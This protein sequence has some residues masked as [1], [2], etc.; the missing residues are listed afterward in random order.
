MQAS[1]F[2]EFSLESTPKIFEALVATAR[3]EVGPVTLKWQARS[4]TKVLRYCW[5]W[6]LLTLVMTYRVN[7]DCGA[8]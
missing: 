8:V 6:R 5:L 4:E 1:I 7:Y 3:K 2:V